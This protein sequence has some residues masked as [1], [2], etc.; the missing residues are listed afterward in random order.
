VVYVA[1]SATPIRLGTI[2]GYHR[3]RGS[4][5]RLLL[6]GAR[7]VAPNGPTPQHPPA[8]CAQA[9]CT[10]AAALVP[11][12][13]LHSSAPLKTG[14]RQV[15]LGP[16]VH[17]RYPWA[18]CTGQPLRRLTPVVERTF[19]WFWRD[20]RLVTD[21]EISQKRWRGSLLCVAGECQHDL[22]TG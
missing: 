12:Y 16:G 18:L 6:R 3:G 5:P 10:R 7:A 9:R 11:Q 22:G 15:R 4:Q 13:P 2:L 17:L 21:L 14:A 19:S 8:S 1:L 20:R